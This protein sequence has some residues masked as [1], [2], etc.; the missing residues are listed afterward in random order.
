MPEDGDSPER[1]GTISREELQALPD[2][3]AGAMASPVM[4]PP[5]RARPWTS[6]SST[7]PTTP[8]KTMGTDLGHLLRRHGCWAQPTPGMTL[9]LASP[10]V[11]QAA[12]S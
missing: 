9:T 7:G 1:G 2:E 8:T 12:E 11:R 10:R 4:F 3:V 6:P 5:G